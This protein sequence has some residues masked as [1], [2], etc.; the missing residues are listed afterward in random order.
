MTPSQIRNDQYLELA[1][2]LRAIQLQVLAALQERGPSTTRQLADAA[3]IDLLTVRPRVTE[4]VQLGLVALEGR[5]G[6]EGVYRAC[7]LVEIEATR[8]RER[9]AA[10]NTQPVQGTLFPL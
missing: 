2:S 7:T 5:E 10:R 1:P 4:L 8:W 9:S 3:R 6:H